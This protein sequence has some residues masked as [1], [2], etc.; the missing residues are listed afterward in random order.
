M[1]LVHLLQVYISREACPTIVTTFRRRTPAQ[2]AM[3]LCQLTRP[4]TIV[5]TEA[6]EFVHN[7]SSK[8]IWGSMLLESSQGAPWG[9]LLEEY[10]SPF[11]S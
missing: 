11:V 8:P 6:H 1:L 3:R 10:Q 2:F 5:G 9:P 7:L 4:Y